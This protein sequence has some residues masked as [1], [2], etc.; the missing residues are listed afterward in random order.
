LIDIGGSSSDASID[1]PINPGKYQPRYDGTRPSWGFFV[2]HAYNIS[3]INCTVSV[4]TDKHDGRP[5]VVMDDVEMV[6]WIGEAHLPKTYGECA[7][8]IRNVTDS[9][10]GGVGSSPCVWTPRLH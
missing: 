2:R 8:E 5:S 9:N 3:F 4:A 1:P 6:Q 7:L 10:F